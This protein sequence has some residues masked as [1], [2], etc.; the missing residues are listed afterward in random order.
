MPSA[1]ALFAAVHGST[2]VTTP[3]LARSR[4]RDPSHLVLAD[5][6]RAG[7]GPAR[8]SRTGRTVRGEDRDDPVKTGL[9]DYVP[10]GGRW[11]RNDQ[12]PAPLGQRIGDPENRVQACR[13]DETDTLQVKED[14]KGLGA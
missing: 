10:G 4:S 9:L 1:P 11:T 13:A 14:M 6:H 2:S 3:W 7:S 8:E 12:P 5:Q